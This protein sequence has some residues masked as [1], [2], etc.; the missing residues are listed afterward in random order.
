MSIHEFSIDSSQLVSQSLRNV[1]QTYTVFSTGLLY[2]LY[3]LY[4]LYGLYGICYWTR[5][6]QYIH[7]YDDRLDTPIKQNNKVIMERK[8]AKFLPLLPS[9]TPNITFP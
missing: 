9:K 8:N 2:A 3:E 7:H 6:P 1:K 4:E 5:T